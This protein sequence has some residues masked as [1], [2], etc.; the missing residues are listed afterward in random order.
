MKRRGVAPA[1]STV[2]LVGAT[3]AIAIAAY[4]YVASSLAISQARA[5][6]EDAKKAFEEI[7]R[8]LNAF[9]F[10]KG[11]SQTVPI[12]LAHGILETRNGNFTMTITIGGS[13][14]EILSSRYYELRFY[15]EVQDEKEVLY[16]EKGTLITPPDELKPLPIVYVDQD[17]DGRWFV[18]LN[19]SR[20]AIVDQGEVAGYKVYSVWRILIDDVEFSGSG[21]TFNIKV[22]ISEVSYD[23]YYNVMRITVNGEQYNITND[24]EEEPTMVTVVTS[25]V[26]IMVSP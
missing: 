1:L 3:I 8:W 5:N 9:A 10:A 7:A 22:L 20:I 11:A 18:A 24:V 25:H 15:G 17:E 6:F 16:G 26:K 23:T 13:G 14:S 21:T 2:I 4:Q 19:T 12:S